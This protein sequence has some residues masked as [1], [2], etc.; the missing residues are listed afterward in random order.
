MSGNIEVGQHNI[1]PLIF[2][3]SM[4]FSF[5]FFHFFFLFPPLPHP[6]LLVVI[7]VAT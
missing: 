3:L 6:S 7:R 5:S 1:I 4:F 2:A